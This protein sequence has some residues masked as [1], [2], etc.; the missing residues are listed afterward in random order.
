[1]TCSVYASYSE[2][3]R[4]SARALLNVLLGLGSICGC[5]VPK[6]PGELV[7]AYHITGQLT[8]NSCGT[9]ALPAAN[10]LSFDVEIRQ[11][12]G[13]GLWVRDMPPPHSGRLNDD[14]SFGFEFTTSYAISGMPN[15]PAATT[16]VDPAK[17]ADPTLVDTLDQQALKSC[18]LSV[19]ETIDG[20]L[21]REASADAGTGTSSKASSSSS[22]GP[23]LV[24]DNEI[25][26]QAAAGSSCDMVLAAQGG[27]FKTLPCSAHYDLKGQLSSP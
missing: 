26:I 16:D 27:P 18:Q 19:D 22:A 8:D 5:T 3:M 20:T 25:A 11:D 6:T 4:P 9:S 23:D 1:L 14:G 21:L 2:R 15:Q 13:A 7:G 24:A 17:L 10:S 12:H